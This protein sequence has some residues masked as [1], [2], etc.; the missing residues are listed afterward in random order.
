M[1]LNLPGFGL[2]K[3]GD[4]FFILS[5]WTPA[6]RFVGIVRS[7]GNQPLQAAP[8]YTGYC[9]DSPWLLYRSSSTGV[10]GVR[11]RSNYPLR[12]T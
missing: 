10:G 1:A 2:L 7:L 4:P 6:T 5:K 8:A 12:G 9:R 3:S 11:L